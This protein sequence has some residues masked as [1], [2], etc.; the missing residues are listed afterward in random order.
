MGLGG[1]F[2][3]LVK[4]LLTWAVSKVHI[5][6]RFTEKI[7][8][9]RGLRQGY[10]LSPL[11]FSLSTQP[12]MDYLQYQLNIGN[13]EG[14]HISN[15]LTI[16][17]ILFSDNVGIF[18]Q[19]MEEGFM[20]L[21]EALHVYKMASSAKLILAKLVIVLLAMSIIPQWL[22]NT[23]CSINKPGKVQKYLG[24]PFDQQIRSKV[25]YNFCLKRISEKIT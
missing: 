13:L 2:T 23:R 7:P 22:T 1:T 12:L 8:L 21:R 14:I 25:M 10:P 11:I 6:G 9:T 17:H 18:I 20:K 5:N 24:E 4:G 3:R 16:Y 19:A 15:D